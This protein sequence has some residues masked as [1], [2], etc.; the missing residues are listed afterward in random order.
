MTETTR[1]NIGLG[2][3][4]LVTITVLTATLASGVHAQNTADGQGA[5]RERGRGGPQGGPGGPGGPGRFGGPGGRGG[6]GGPMGALGTINRLDLSDAQ[7]DQIKGIVDSRRE[8]TNALADRARSGH[9]ALQ[10][11]VTAD[12]FDEGTIRARS[13][14]VASVEADM[15]VARARL[16][17]DVLQILTSDQQS[18]LKELQA[19][20]QARRPDRRPPG[21]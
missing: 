21:H 20:M 9:E 3:A 6:P 16:H 11:A 18:K 19:E 4:A 2:I 5:F 15:A 14:D 10:A 7:R 17:A 1:S 13:S 8:E 12:T